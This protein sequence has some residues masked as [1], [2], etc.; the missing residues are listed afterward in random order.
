MNS[1]TDGQ[2]YFLQ[3]DFNCDE[4]DTISTELLRPCLALETVLK[5]SKHG[6]QLEQGTS[7]C[8]SGREVFL[9]Q[10]FV[11]LRTLGSIEDKLKSSVEV[12]LLILATDDIIEISG[13]HSI[14]VEDNVGEDALDPLSEGDLGFLARLEE[15]AH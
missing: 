13:C 12:D 9:N 5:K 15:E 11:H 8:L 10:K 6:L 4:I 14:E 7:K 1:L 2:H 3:V